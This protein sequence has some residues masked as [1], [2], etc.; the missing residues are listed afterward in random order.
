MGAWSL[1]PF[2]IDTALTT[3]QSESFNSQIKRFLGKE[4]RVDMLVLAV[5]RFTEYRQNEVLVAQYRVGGKWTLRSHLPAFYDKN[6]PGV[7]I[8]KIRS[9]K[10]YLDRIRTAQQV[11]VIPPKSVL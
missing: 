11:E 7:E 3:N 2:G 9:M 8:P 4:M 10:E 5:Q 1:R 6:A